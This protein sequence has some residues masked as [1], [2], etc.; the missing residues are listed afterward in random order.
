MEPTN[1][2]LRRLYKLIQRNWR[3]SN[4]LYDFAPDLEVIKG[5]HLAVFGTPIDHSNWTMTKVYYIYPDGAYIDEDD[6]QGG[7]K[8][9]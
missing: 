7:I 9:E 2:Q 4:L 6:T 3:Q 1:E 8:Y 5:C